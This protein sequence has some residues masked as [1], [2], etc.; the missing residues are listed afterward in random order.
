MLTVSKND[1]GGV[2]PSCGEAARHI[3]AF[4]HCP[5]RSE[6]FHQIADGSSSLIG[7]AEIPV[8]GCRAISAQQTRSQHKITMD[9]R[10]HVL[11][12]TH[13]AGIAE[14]ERLPGRYR[15]NEIRYD[16]VGRPVAPTD[17]VATPRVRYQYAIATLGQ[18]CAVGGRN[19]FG[20]SLGCA[21]GI[22]A[23]ERILLAVSPDPILVAIDLVSGDTDHSLDVRDEPRRFEHMRCSQRI[24]GKGRERISEGFRNQRL[25][26]KMNDDGGPL[27]LD[28][29]PNRGEIPDVTYG[30]PD[31]IDD[32]GSGKQA[33]IGGRRKCEAGDIAA[34]LLEPAHEPPAREAGMAGYKNPHAL[35]CKFEIQQRRFRPHDARLRPC[36]VDADH[37]K[38]G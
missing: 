17:N 38:D 35:Q 9:K 3:T 24:G 11:P 33:G 18:R 37:F 5:D 20:A 36:G 1:K 19:Q 4:W 6:L 31:A 16:P 27:P 34:D 32:I 30:R 14:C 21:I 25:C 26:G 12:G 7:G 15:P 28:R 10:H 29:G 13:G 22:L 23:A 2:Q 8:I